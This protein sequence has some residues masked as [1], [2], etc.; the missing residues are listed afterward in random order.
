MYF[1][2][3]LKVAHVQNMVTAFT[4]EARFLRSLGSVLRAMDVEK[5]D[6]VGSARL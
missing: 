3:L 1:Q 2:L 5:A 6:R 4:L